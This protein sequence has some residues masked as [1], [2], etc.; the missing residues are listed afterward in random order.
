VRALCCTATMVHGTLGRMHQGARG[1]TAIERWSIRLAPALGM[2]AIVASALVMTDSEARWALVY[3][4][5]TDQPGPSAWRIAM[6]RGSP[7]QVLSAPGIGL[8]RLSYGGEDKA[9]IPFETDADGIA[10]VTVARPAAAHAAPIDAQIL[11]GGY[12]L[13]TGPVK[14]ATERWS[15]GKRSDG[16]WCPGYHEGPVDIQLGMI[17]GV[18]LHGYPSAA[19]IALTEAG[20]AL[21]NQSIFVETEGA[22]ILGGLAVT[23]I[24]LVTDARGLVHLSVRSSDMAA[25]LT[26][27]VPEPK[28]SR[29]TAALPIRA[30]GLRALRTANEL[31]VSTT[32]QTP[33][34]W[35]GVMTEHGLTQVQSVALASSGEYWRATATFTD[36]PKPPLWA[37]V[38][39]EP[40]L[41]SMNTIGWPLLEESSNDEPHATFVVPNVLALDGRTQVL[42]RLD[43]QRDRAVMI[44]SIALL[45]VATLV[46]WVLLRANRRHQRQVSVL[47]RQLD[48]PAL[49][50]KSPLALIAILVTTAAFVALAFWVALGVG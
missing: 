16:G 3:A 36:W 43:K 44:S 29:F 11:E 41:D 1:L 28:P 34:A 8:L 38:S 25:T 37:V 12:V 15:A 47:A 40:E 48:S 20:H 50:D 30:G 49:A 23:K 9:D 13:A 33:R 26:V 24:A 22:K 10:W 5:P 21:A 6:K 7:N 27:T 42:R 17:D 4:G 46:A 45:G 18:M 35:L 39:A 14:V 19:L 31:L 2:A 32:V